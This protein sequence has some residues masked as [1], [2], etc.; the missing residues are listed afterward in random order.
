MFT[1][2]SKHILLLLSMAFVFGQSSATGSKMNLSGTVTDKNTGEKLPGVT[3]YIPDL[4]TGGITDAN[5]N[6]NIDN[7]PLKKL[8]FQF[9]LI[10]YKNYIT[11][12]DLAT[13]STVSIMLEESVKEINAIV[14]TG[15][16]YAV[17]KTRTPTP[18]TVIQKSLIVE[19]SSSNLID[20]LAT[21]PGIS[22]ITTGSGISK[23]VIR[24]LGYNRVIV[25][26]DG[27]KQ[28]GQQWGDEH[29]IE[30][31]EYGVDKVE[32][33]KGPASLMYG[34]DAMA[35][36]INMI[37]APSLAEGKI[38]SEILSEYQTN[39]GLYGYSLNSKG[40]IKGYVWDARFSNKAAHSYQNKFDGYVYNSGFKEYSAQTL[41]GINRSWGFSHLTLSYYNMIPA[42][43]EGERD[44]LTGKFT[45]PIVVNDSTVEDVVAN[46]SDFKSYS[47]N[48]P[49]QKINHY[50]AVL[51]NSVIIKQG[52]LKSTIG[53]QLNER[54]EF[55]DIEN[56]DQYGLYFKLHTINYEVKY[57]FPEFKK[58]NLTTG[59][60]GMFQQS[61]NEG[62]E[63]LVPAYKLADGGIFAIAARNF[64]KIDLSAGIRFDTRSIKGDDLF[65]DDKGLATSENNSV[66]QKFKS[67]NSTFSGFTGSL[68]IAWNFNPIYYTKAN[69]SF[70][71]RAPNIA[72]LGANGLHE[73]TIRYE[74]GNVNLKAERSSQLDLA[75]GVNTD[76]LSIELDG[77]V[78]YIDNFIFLSKLPNVSGT[79]SIIDGN[80]A[81]QYSAGNAILKGGEVL[82]DLHP[83]PFD[84]LH[85][86]NSFSI[87]NAQQQNQ[88]DSSKYLPF[89][90][91]M[92]ITSELQFTQKKLFNVLGNCFF[93]F[94]LDYYFEQDQIYSAYNT[95]T[96][97]PGYVLLHAGIG[98][99]IMGKKK[100]LLSFYFNI[101]NLGD[102][103]YQSHLS[104]LKYAPDNLATGRTGIFNIGRSFNFKVMIPFDFSA[105]TP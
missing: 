38:S 30:I 39:N 86:E 40:N 69:V 89:T 9:S 83:H 14:V 75:L 41:L 6:F 33:L 17:E 2:I 80:Y 27:V 63:F 50:K 64:N 85:F 1:K 46:N 22:Q 56:P 103:G 90:P 25:V 62:T 18:I 101:T 34:S 82:F 52:T 60:N 71:F 16:A 32:I 31:D 92:K 88:P 11:T 66:E 48:V 97:T 91:P 53:Y 77:F 26:N 57:H 10:G 19:N 73:G 70:G 7:L 35:G 4:K 42:I 15:S 102:V 58:I 72:E 20:A 5:G 93:K 79:D 21:Q 37:S 44:D 81:F 105:K 96:K 98:T 49:Y 3:I 45:K 23:P 67:F 95:E 13:T 94:G 51:N 84:W 29:G 47:A 100:K 99:D 55:A 68:G 24:G 87:V 65:L 36:V 54:K 78:N 76:H 12:I 43:S 28:E 8:V 74:I 59:I 104:R 61:K